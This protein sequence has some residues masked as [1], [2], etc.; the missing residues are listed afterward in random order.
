MDSKERAILEHMFNEI[1]FIES[2]TNAVPFE[3]F[4]DSELLKRGV[5]MALLNIGELA[6]ALDFDFYTEHSQV[7][8]RDI[9]GLRNAAAH[10]Y[11]AL[12]LETVW[13]TIQQDIPRLK[14][15]L[16]DMLK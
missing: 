15:F 11:F 14:A 10:G 7:P 16:A 13:A 2:E 5:V 3:Q 12:R 1:T 6:N 8:W 9:I 4:K